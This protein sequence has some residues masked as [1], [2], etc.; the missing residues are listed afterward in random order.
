[1]GKKGK[2][3]LVGSQVFAR[4]RPFGTAEQGGHTADGEAVAKQL[5]SW[6]GGGLTIEDSAGQATTTEKFDFPKEVLGPDS[7]Q[8][9]TF[10]AVTADLLEDWL[11]GKNNAL[12]FAYGQTGTG[13]TH[14]MFGTGDS[15]KSEAPHD[16]WGLMPRIV[17]ACLERNKAQAATHAAALY[18]SAIDFYSFAGWDLNAAERSY[19]D[20]RTDGTVVGHTETKLESTAMIADFIDRVYGNRKVTK[21]KMNAGSSRSHVCIMLTLYQM[22][23]ATRE[24]TQTTFTIAD[25]AGSERASKTGG[26]RM[27]INE[28]AGEAMMALRPGGKEMSVGAQG[29]LINHELS[30]ITTSISKAT[31]EWKAG[32]PYKVPTAMVPPCVWFLGGCCTGYAKLGVVVCFSQSPQNGWESWYSCTWGRECAKLQAPCN[33]QKPVN[34]EKEIK[35][36][37]KESKAA[38]AALAKTDLNSESGK[39]Y[40]FYRHGMCHYWKERVSIL[41]ELSTADAGIPGGKVHEP[42]KQRSGILAILFHRKASGPKA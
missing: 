17:H 39:K 35:K 11:S 41:E 32:R 36:A 31:D 9:Q 3:A 22:D 29:T 18:V 20:V 40:I 37:N 33:T 30:Q 14:T 2:K 10:D 15:L 5:K 38:D 19:V 23:H 8:Q 26:E 6:E 21:T 4:I 34:V 12:L 24:F 27:G 1:M 28:A 16:D 42:V 25:L 13:K 7:T